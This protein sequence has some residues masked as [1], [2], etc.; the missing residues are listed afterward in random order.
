MLY[1]EGAVIIRRYF[2]FFGA[3]NGKF[4]FV[5]TLFIVAWDNGGGWSSEKYKIYKLLD[6]GIIVLSNTI[7]FQNVCEKDLC[8]PF[9]KLKDE[10]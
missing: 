8:L 5:I 1:P 2:M 6:I 3:G 4:T 10:G 7:Y 9:K